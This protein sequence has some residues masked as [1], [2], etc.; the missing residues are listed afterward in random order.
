MISDENYKKLIKLKAKNSFD[1]LKSGKNISDS[2]LVDI[3]SA[4]SNDEL[5]KLYEDKEYF[6]SRSLKE[7]EFLK[8]K[9]SEEHQTKNI[10]LTNSEYALVFNVNQTTVSRWRNSKTFPVLSDLD[11]VYSFF[12]TRK[13]KPKKLNSLKKAKSL[14]EKIT[15]S[16][17]EQDNT[18]VE[19]LSDLIS[20]YRLKILKADAWKKDFLNQ[21]LKGKFVLAEEVERVFYIIFE[22][23]MQKFSDEI[24]SNAD[25]FEKITITEYI[26]LRNKELEKVRQDIVDEFT[27]QIN[28]IKD[29]VTDSFIKRNTSIPKTKN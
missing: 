10:E 17:T 5:K 4:M 9:F 2:E 14:F 28:H 16:K 7:Q 13:N 19:S 24:D 1:K 8:N 20:E 23:I 18:S 15:G 12:N 25:L 11:K 21:I 26:D 29:V 6:N 3:L 27:E 22:N